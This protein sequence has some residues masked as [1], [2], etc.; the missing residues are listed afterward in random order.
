MRR[1]ELTDYKVPVMNEAGEKKEEPYPVKNSLVELLMARDNRLSGRELLARD[2]IAR[3]ILAADSTIL[4]EEEEWNKLVASAE[5][6]TGFGRTD[7]E[8]LKR[9]FE[10][11]QVDVEEKI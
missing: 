1:I 11:P 3:K 8:L 4:L 9:I 6:V 10:S 2:E 7:A 5:T